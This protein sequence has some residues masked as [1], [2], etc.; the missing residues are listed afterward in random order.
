MISSRLFGLHYSFSL[1]LFISFFRPSR[2]I[3]SRANCEYIHHSH[4][5]KLI[6]SS[7]SQMQAFSC[8][9]LALFWCK[10]KVSNFDFV[11]AQNNSTIDFLTKSLMLVQ[12]IVFSVKNNIFTVEEGAKSNLRL[13]YCPRHHLVKSDEKSRSCLLKILP[14][15]LWR[16]KMWFLAKRFPVFVMLWI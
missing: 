3:T 4:L 8:W 5:T 6:A 10:Q 9:L 16:E 13:Y 15:V 1:E 7:S 12:N 2:S 11:P 14:S